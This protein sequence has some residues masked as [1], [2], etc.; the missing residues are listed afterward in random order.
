MKFTNKIFISKKVLIIFM[1][2]IVFSLMWGSG[3]YGFGPDYYGAYLSKNLN[4]SHWYTDRLGWRIATLTIFD[5]RLGVYIT[6]FLLAF[7][8]GILV[9]TY[10]K[11]NNL[12]SLPIFI[13][14]FIIILHTWPVMM[15]T[16]NAMRQGI[17]MSFVFLSLSQL[18][19][20][21]FKLSFL[22]ILLSYFSH[23]SGSIYLL[24]YILMLIYFKFVTY[25]YNNQRII[26]LFIISVITSIIC[27]YYLLTGSYDLVSKRVIGGDFRIPFF[28]INM[29]YLIFFTL[30]FSNLRFDYLNV[31]IYLF[32]FSALSLLILKFNWQ[33]ERLNMMMTIPYL[34]VIADL[35]R[36]RQ[37]LIIWVTFSILLL[38]LTIYTGMYDSLR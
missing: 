18:Y 6:S 23:T 31:F 36:N 35:F 16:T 21:N 13:F 10:F 33:Y 24:I 15:S 2:S 9:N 17:A 1:I 37:K 22:L 25:F 7:S 34:L 12:Y 14:I 3:F 28:I 19:S 8:S 5:V 38:M 27:Y 4:W 20:K 26:V 30:F 32:S 11:K 29:G